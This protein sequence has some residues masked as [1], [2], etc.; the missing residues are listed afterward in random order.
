MDIYRVK[1]TDG[2]I[3]KVRAST[4]EAAASAVRTML[5]ADAPAAPAVPRRT[6]NDVG[7]TLRTLLGQGAGFGFGDSVHI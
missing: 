5:A 7:N 3:Y 1:G 2:K 4:P 6:G